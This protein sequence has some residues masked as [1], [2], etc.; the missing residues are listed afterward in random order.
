M[1][2]IYFSKVAGPKEPVLS[3][4]RRPRRASTSFT[5]VGLLQ[6]D[7]V[8]SPSAQVRSPQEEWRLRQRQAHARRVEPREAVLNGYYEKQF[9]G[10]PPEAD[11][12]EDHRWMNDSA[13]SWR[14]GTAETAT[15]HTVPR[16][17]T[18]RDI[19]REMMM[20]T[21]PERTAAMPSAERPMVAQSFCSK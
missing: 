20:G 2:R 3:E 14:R 17:Q 21:A 10:R 1:R 4:R 11:E 8:R 13:S 16:A 18:P 5:P 19:M 7:Y 9:L 15:A 12:G 6:R